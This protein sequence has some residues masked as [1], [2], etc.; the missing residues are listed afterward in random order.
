MPTTVKLDEKMVQEAVKL[1]NFKTTQ[2]AMNMALTEFVERRN[3]LHILEL[4]GKI[5]FRPDWDYQKMR[6]RR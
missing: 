3:R 2:E 4:A 5:E 1:G 6:T